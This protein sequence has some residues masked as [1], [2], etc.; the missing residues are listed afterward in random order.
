MGQTSC[1]TQRD[2]TLPIHPQRYAGGASGRVGSGSA[3]AG[4]DQSAIV[5]LFDKYKEPGHEMILAE[6]IGRFCEDLGVDPSDVAMLVL[7]WHF[8]ADIMCQYSKDEFVQGMV[9]LGCD[10]LGKLAGRLGEL[11]AELGRED[12]FKEVY[13]YAFSF[14]REQGQKILQL[15]TALGMWQ[16]LFAG[17]SWPHL[18]HWL[19]FLQEKHGKAISRDTWTQFYN[20]TMASACQHRRCMPRCRP[21][22][23]SI[24]SPIVPRQRI[25]PDFSDYDAENGAWP[26]IIDDFVAWMQE[27]GKI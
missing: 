15:D 21:C 20:F 16:L 13:L 14:A 24:L 25:R 2:P 27:T 6:G 22:D 7:S 19:T 11:R 5:A 1:N 12:R 4:V 23:R 10:S 18:D 3:S 8:G 26:V 9:K 17:R